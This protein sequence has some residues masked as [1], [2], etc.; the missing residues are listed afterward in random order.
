MKKIVFF[1]VSLLAIAGCGTKNVD[2]TK[3]GVILPKTGDL[4]FLG[5]FM[6]NSLL[7]DSLAVQYYIED[8]SGNPKDAALAAQK[9]ISVNKVDY[10]VSS[11]SFLSEA[12][13]PI[14]KQHDVPHFILSFSPVLANENN[15]IQPFVNSY[16]EAEAFVDYIKNNG[17]SS[18]VFLRHIETDADYV[19][20][21]YTKNK[22]EELGVNVTSVSFDN[23]TVRDFKSDVLKVKQINPDLLVIQAL[24][25]NI[26]NIIS[27]LNNYN[28]DIPVLGDLNFLDIQDDELKKSL[29]GIPF[30]GLNYILSDNY[31]NYA[32]KYSDKYSKQPFVLGAFAYDLGYY[33]SILSRGLTDKEEILSILNTSNTMYTVNSERFFNN[34]GYFDLKCGIY[35][36]HG[37]S[38]VEYE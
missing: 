22:L 19:F 10:I 37:T 21:S 6:G 4:S 27:T 2:L 26:P 8:C 16:Q 13:N 12:I 11:L 17:V 15:V 1:I 9:L 30:V 20:E 23:K 34:N 24:A 25:Y 32:H 31:L 29:N 3:V 35:T 18:V 7:L 5:E 28:V 14:C 36:F 38:Y 33:L